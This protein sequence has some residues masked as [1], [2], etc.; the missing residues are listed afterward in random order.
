VLI[1]PQV[2]FTGTQMGFGREE[3]DINLALDRL[4]RAL[5]SVGASWKTVATTN[6]YALTRSVAQRIVPLRQRRIEPVPARPDT[7]LIFEA[8]P[9]V[10]ASFAMEAVAIVER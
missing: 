4:G 10:D 3:N 2:A 7:T 6:T 5:E 8:L 1:A 9:S